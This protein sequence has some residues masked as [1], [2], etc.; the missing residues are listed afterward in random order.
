MSLREKIEKDIM[1]GPWSHLLAHHKRNCL[2]LVSPPVDLVTAAES[3]AADQTKVV[4]A[5]LQSGHFM[6]PTDELVENW[7]PDQTFKFVIVQ[8]FVLVEFSTTEKK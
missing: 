8:P 4:M 3:V 2:F 6:R 5:W 7:S 1:T